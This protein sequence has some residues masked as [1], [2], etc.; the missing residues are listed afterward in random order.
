VGGEKAQG[1]G[2]EGV[3]DP[4]EGGGYSFFVG[5]STSWLCG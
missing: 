2:G 1:G 3:A 5:I 4:A